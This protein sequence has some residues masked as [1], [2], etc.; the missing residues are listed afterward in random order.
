MSLQSN[1]PH[2]NSTNVITTLS[3]NNLTTIPGSGS[4]K[5]QRT[6]GGKKQTSKSMVQVSPR[7]NEKI[8]NIDYS[9]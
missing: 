3:N 5:K 6:S 8:E 7:F 2:T 4:K 1:N 9:G